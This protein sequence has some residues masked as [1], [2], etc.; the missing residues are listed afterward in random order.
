[1]TSRV[2]GVH[3]GLTLPSFVRDVDEALAVAVAAEAAGLDGV[4]VY[5]H[6]FR[7]AADGSRRPA[8]ESTALLGAVAAATTRIHVGPLVERATLRSHALTAFT[9]ATV[10]RLTDGRFIGALGAGD[11]E[12]E[13]ENETFGLDF[14]TID[15]RLA[16]LTDTVR[17]T[18]DQ[19]FPVWVGG[20]HPR[21]RELAAA[22]ADGWNHWGGDPVLFGEEAASVAARAVRSPFS[23]TWGGLVVLER[24]DER[25]REKAERLHAS[26]GT[27]VGG[28]AT[29]AA[30]YAAY[31]D[32]GA[33]W[34]IAGPVDS[35]NP[36][37][38][39]LL[40]DVK[41]RLS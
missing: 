16:A 8:L 14:G 12:S 36:A 4:F 5:D 23:C 24:D 22:E 30:A 29:V 17:A 41:S 10:Q 28:P 32:V 39:D 9:F 37:N 7:F 25:A 35:R 13:A 40:A 18:R 3:F 27:I 19:G 31:V 2:D 11:H 1:V 15:D 20:T 38:A 26:A 34:V 33:S 21:V 6:L